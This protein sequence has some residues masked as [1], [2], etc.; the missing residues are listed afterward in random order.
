MNV[1]LVERKM[2]VCT[3]LQTQLYNYPVLQNGFVPGDKT[4][5]KISNS[6]LV[7]DFLTKPEFYEFSWLKKKSS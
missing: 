3:I 4:K 7:E 1:S 2:V 5:K 6:F